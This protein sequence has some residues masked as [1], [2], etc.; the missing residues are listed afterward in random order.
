MSD[1]R[2]PC[3]GNCIHFLK[4]ERED[5]KYLGTCKNPECVWDGLKRRETEGFFC[6]DFELVLIDEIEP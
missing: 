3:C 5:G 2:G 1:S 4:E 6:L